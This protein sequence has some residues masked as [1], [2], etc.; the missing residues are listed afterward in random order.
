VHEAV[1]QFVPGDNVLKTGFNN[2]GTVLHPTLM[3]L[4]SGWIE[5]P[6]DFEFYHQGTSPSVAR[7]LEK[8]DAERV[9]VAAAL[10]LRGM[11]ARQWL[12]FAYDAAGR[13]LFDAI[14]A[15]PGYGGILAP[16]RLEMRYL[17]EDVPCSLVPMASV[18]R[19]FGVPTPTLDSL[20]HLASALLDR[21]FRSEGRTVEKL[22]IAGM[23]LRALRLLAIGE[24]AA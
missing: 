17:T 13:S 16:H 10:G 3:V 5:D 18:G 20:I 6:G 12:Y 8:A 19:K 9:A 2:V 15:Q 24:R 7:V 14:H 23:D 1:P 22:G 21:D 11:S 4:N